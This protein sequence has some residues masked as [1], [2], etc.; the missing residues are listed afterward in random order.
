M[1][2]IDSIIVHCSATKAGQDFTIIHQELKKSI[3]TITNID[4]NF[5]LEAPAGQ[6]VYYRTGTHYVR[7]I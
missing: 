1:R 5:S 6:R 2:K 3:G 7:G 4:G